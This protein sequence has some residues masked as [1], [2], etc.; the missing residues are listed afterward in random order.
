VTHG[1][2]Q[3]S[4]MHYSL[5]SLPTGP[6][7]EFPSI[8][9]YTQAGFQIPLGEVTPLSV[10]NFQ[11]NSPGLARNVLYSQLLSAL[12]P[13]SQSGPTLG[14]QR[15]VFIRPPWLFTLINAGEQDVFISL[16][17]GCMVPPNTWVIV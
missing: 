2:I 8:Y 3:D 6:I 5:A 4:P 12:S 16:L 7:T 9:D 17:A 14:L 11:V 15:A 1:V 13:L 10:G